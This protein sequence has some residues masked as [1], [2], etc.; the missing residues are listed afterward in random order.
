MNSG[1]LGGGFIGV[2]YLVREI[3]VFGEHM[4]TNVQEYSLCPTCNNYESKT[5]RTN[6]GKC[7]TE[8]IKKCPGCNSPFYDQAK[9]CT[10]CGHKLIT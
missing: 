6:C 2:S 3:L 10:Q 4:A 1:L 8:L 9:H 5:F 7:G